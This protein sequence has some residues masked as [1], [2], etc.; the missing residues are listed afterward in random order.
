MLVIVALPVQLIVAARSPKYSMTRLVPPWTVS[1]PARR[2]ITSLG[3]VQPAS[4]PV[5]R[6]PTSRGCSTS[7]GNPAITS[8]ASAPPT[9]TASIAR[10]PA[11]GVC[12]SVP[13]IRPPGTA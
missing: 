1:I 11:F 9:P 5:S 13:I 2:R 3:A 12:E 4:L 8:P 7:H 6:T 10:P